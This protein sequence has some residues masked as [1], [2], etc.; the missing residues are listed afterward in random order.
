MGVHHSTTSSVAFSLRWVCTT[1]AMSALETV[2]LG[3]FGDRSGSDH[4]AG[5]LRLARPLC[6][7]ALD[8]VHGGAV[9]GEPRIAAEIRALARVRHRA[10]NQFAVLEDRL[11][12]GNSRRPVGSHGGQC[13]VP[14]RV[15]QRP[16]AL[17]ELRLCL[18]DIPPRRHPPMMAP[19]AGRGDNSRGRAWP[20]TGRPA[21]HPFAEQ[22]GDPGPAHHPSRVPRHA[23]PAAGER[24]Q[25]GSTAGASVVLAPMRT[26][27]VSAFRP[28]GRCRAAAARPKTG[29]LP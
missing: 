24:R 16:H 9:Q 25:Y 18:V 5:D 3:S 20:A 1:S 2:A 27:A 7:G 21:R 15:E 17:G 4:P 22:V 11:D 19:P 28:M 26:A 6:L 13:L 8:R 12:P 29:M 10:K 23:A 14:V